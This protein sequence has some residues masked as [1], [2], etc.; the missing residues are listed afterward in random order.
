MVVI[1]QLVGLACV[2]LGVFLIN[3]PAGFITLGL[4]AV[5]IGITLERIDAG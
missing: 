3:V 5:L 1:V 4:T 2:D